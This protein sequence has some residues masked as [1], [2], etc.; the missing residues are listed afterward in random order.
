M[1]GEFYTENFVRELKKFYKKRRPGT[2][3]RGIKLLHDNARPHMSKS[4]ETI[5][6]IM[7]EVIAYPPYSPGLSL[8]YMA[9][10]RAKKT[11]RGRHFDTRQDMG[12]AI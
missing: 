7:F 5:E 1:T 3:A 4:L 2:G 9:I 11:S 12:T 8:R 6:D 10:F